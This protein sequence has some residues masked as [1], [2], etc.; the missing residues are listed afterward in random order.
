MGDELRVSSPILSI[1]NDI[2]ATHMS[3]NGLPREAHSSGLVVLGAIET[4]EYV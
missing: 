1:M 2:G 3:D 4:K